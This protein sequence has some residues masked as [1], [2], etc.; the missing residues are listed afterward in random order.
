MLLHNQHRNDKGKIAW[1]TPGIL[2]VRLPPRQSRGNSHFVLD[3]LKNKGTLPG[4]LDGYRGV[5]SPD[6]PESTNVQLASQD[7]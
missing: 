1:M 2:K 6:R 5:L 3:T 4:A 7:R